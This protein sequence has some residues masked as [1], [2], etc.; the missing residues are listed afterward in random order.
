MGGCR[1]LV[2]IVAGVQA[3]GLSPQVAAGAAAV[4]AYVAGLTLIARATPA[5]S[6]RVVPVLIAGIALVDAA[7]IGVVSGSIGWMAAAAAGF[8][9][10]LFLQR[11]VAGD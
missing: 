5:D 8:A 7:F 9:V 10:T 1:A 4:G 11:Y 6:R 3:G 2:Y